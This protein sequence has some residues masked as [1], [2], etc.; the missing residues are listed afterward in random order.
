[1]L[2][3]Q[4]VLQ[5][6]VNLLTQ[7]PDFQIPAVKVC[8]RHDPYFNQEGAIAFWAGWKTGE[9]V[10][11]PDHMEKATFS[12]LVDTLKHELVHAWV[13]WNKLDRS[14]AKGHG[15]PFIRKAIEL[16][17]DIDSTLANYPESRRIYERIKGEKVS[18]AVSQQAEKIQAQKLKQLQEQKDFET[19]QREWLEEQDRSNFRWKVGTWIFSIVFGGLMVFGLCSIIFAPYHPAQPLTEPST[20]NEWQ[21]SVTDKYKARTLQL[22]QGE[23]FVIETSAPNQTVAGVLNNGTSFWANNGVKLKAKEFG[24]LMLWSEKPGE[25]QVKVRRQ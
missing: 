12:Q 17:L 19:R 9:M 24:V 10:I 13:S 6:T 7:S 14:V 22:S 11:R 16:G 23:T 18:T 20:S 2:T 21:G 15:E 1:M 25:Y 4:E 5:N 3:D 8:V